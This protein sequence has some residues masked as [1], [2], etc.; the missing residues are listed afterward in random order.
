MNR[1]VVFNHDIRDINTQVVQ[2]R[3][4]FYRKSVGLLGIWFPCLT[5]RSLLAIS[6]SHYFII[7][8]LSSFF[9]GRAFGTLFSLKFTG[10]LPCLTESL[11]QRHFLSR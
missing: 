1:G 11:S 4:V 5:G 8:L 6:G 10:I 7:V 9:I 3:S 2:L